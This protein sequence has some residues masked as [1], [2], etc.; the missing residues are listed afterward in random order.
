MSNES[1]E[2]QVDRLAKFLNQQFGGEPMGHNEDAIDRA[3]MVIIEL[4]RR[5]GSRAFA[6]QFEVCLGSLSSERLYGLAQAIV[7]HYESDNDDMG[8]GAVWDPP[9]DE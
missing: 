8:D 1:L 9:D 3:M 2:S 5:Q 7:K 4:Q 6:R